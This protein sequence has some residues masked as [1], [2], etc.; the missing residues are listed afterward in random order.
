MGLG[1]FLASLAFHPLLPGPQRHPSLAEF[2]VT[3]GGPFEKSF[4]Y[5]TETSLLVAT[6]HLY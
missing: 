4:F 5:S 6:L 1:V 3:S 2:T